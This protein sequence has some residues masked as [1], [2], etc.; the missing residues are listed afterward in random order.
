MS[1][2]TLVREILPDVFRWEA[3]SPEHKVELSSHAVRH[4]F[5]FLLFDPISLSAEALDW[6]PLSPPTA[7]VLTNENH[8]RA[9]VEW[10]ERFGA[11]IFGPDGAEVMTP[12]VQPLNIEL[13][14]FKEWEMVPLPGGAAG[15]TTF[16]LPEKSLAVFG[17]A[18]VNLPGRGLELLPAKYCLDQSRLRD[19]LAGLLDRFTFA[20]AVFAHGAPLLGEASSRIAELCARPIR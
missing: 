5:E 2:A 7:I 4:G 12:R 10:R 13:R 16:L 3:Y 19:S 15:E 20:N 18:V 11:P 8:R 9:A 6:F 17:D 1:V 14:P